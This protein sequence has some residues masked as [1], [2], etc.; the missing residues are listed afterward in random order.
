MASHCYVRL[1]SV[2]VLLRGHDIALQITQAAMPGSGG[3]DPD[4]SSEWP[5]DDSDASSGEG[6]PQGEPP[7]ELTPPMI[8]SKCPGCLRR[9]CEP[10]RWDSGRAAS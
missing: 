1:Q 2:K 7:D 10:G 3:V 9:A 6:L 4:Y 5:S 8:H